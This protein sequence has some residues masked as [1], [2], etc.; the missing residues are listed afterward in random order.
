LVKTAEH[1]DVGS[2]YIGG[3]TV[4]GLKTMVEHTAG[5]IGTVCLNNVLCSN[6][7]EALVTGEGVL[8][9]LYADG[10]HGAEVR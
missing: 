4:D 2:L 7:A 5:N 8:G 1:A 10:I 9:N 6:V 3:L